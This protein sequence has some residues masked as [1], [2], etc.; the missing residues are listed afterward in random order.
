MVAP[1]QPLTD[2]ATRAALAAAL[3]ETG[4]LEVSGF[5]LLPPPL[6]GPPLPFERAVELQRTMAARTRRRQ[7]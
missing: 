4:W 7:K 3:V 1:D 6:L 5:W 2:A